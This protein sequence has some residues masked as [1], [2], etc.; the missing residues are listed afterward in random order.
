MDAT[1]KFKTLWAKLHCFGL[2]NDYPHLVQI[3]LEHGAD[4]NI[5]SNGIK[6]KHLTKFLIKNII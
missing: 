3:L 4:V 1:R 5:Q 2:L 6:L